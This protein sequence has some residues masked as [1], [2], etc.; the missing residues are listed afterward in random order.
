MRRYLG[1]FIR[2]RLASRIDSIHTMKGRHIARSE[3]RNIIRRELPSTNMVNGQYAI[4]MTD[5]AKSKADRAFSELNPFYHTFNTLH[6][7]VEPFNRLPDYTPEDVELL[8]QDIA[9][10][11]RSVL[12]EV[13]QTVET[14]SDNQYAKCLYDEAASL[15]CQTPPRIRPAPF[16]ANA[17]TGISKMLD[18]RYWNRNLKKYATRWREHLHIAFG[19][20]KRG[21]APY[22]S[23]AVSTTLMNGMP[24]AN[25]AVRSWRAL[26]W[27]TRTPKN[28]FH[29]LS[30]SIR[31][32][33]ILSRSIRA[34]LTP[35]CAALNS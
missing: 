31:A 1:G 5:E 2:L 4:A 25:A 24:D 3:L 35:H 27:R 30:R 8:A 14:L 34:Y 33:L 29:L 18:D 16:I 12:S 17:T 32:Y 26:S 20:V 6:R 19:D 15:F 11:M 28:A 22:C 9:I 23:I 7:L 13:H 10:Y 21:A